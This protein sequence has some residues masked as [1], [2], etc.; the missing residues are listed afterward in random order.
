[1]RVVILVLD[2]GSVF[3]RRALSHTLLPI[4]GSLFPTF[5]SN[6]GSNITRSIRSVE[7]LSACPCLM[8]KNVIEKKRRATNLD[9]GN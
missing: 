6:A 8:Q 9:S 1:M 2:Q 7:K 4:K 3:S 5:L